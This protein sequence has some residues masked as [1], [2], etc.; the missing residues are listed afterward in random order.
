MATPT[1]AP[2]SAHADDAARTIG[3]Y[4]KCMRSRIKRS[5]RGEQNAE[6]LLVSRTDGV[7]SIE[8]YGG[9]AERNASMAA[10]V[11]ELDASG[12]LGDFAPA[13]VQTGDRCVARRG[14]DGAVELH[15]WQ[16]QPVPDELRARLPLRRVLSMCATPRYADVPVPD[17]CFDAWPAAGVAAGG[18]DDACAALAAAGAA[19][20]ADLRLGWHGTAHHHPSRLRLL[21]LAAAHPDRLACYD[22]VGAE[23]A[24]GGAAEAAHRTLLEQVASYAYLLDVQGKGYSSRLKL[25]LHAGRPL[26]IARRPWEEY[27]MAGLVPW[28]HYVPVAENLGDLVERVAWADSH[29]A[30]AAAIAAAAQQFAREHLTRAAAMRALAHALVSGTRPPV[31]GGGGEAV[32]A[33][34][35]AEAEAANGAIPSGGGGDDDDS[36][37]TRASQDR[38]GQQSYYYWHANRTGAVAGMPQGAGA[39]PPPTPQRLATTAAAAATIAPDVRPIATFQLVDDGDVVKVRIALEGD[40]DGAFAAEGTPWCGT[41][42]GDVDFECGE[43][44]LKLTVRARGAA[45]A[46]REFR[47]WVDE[48]AHAI[49]PEQC[50]WRV[51]K[52]R[53]LVVS[54][55]KA[56]RYRSWGKLRMR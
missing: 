52:A 5:G 20:P 18:F 28:T 50:A 44:S 55:R 47:L 13:L 22:V 4:L 12:A 11:R 39:A 23:A 6:M 36:S 34:A 37:K 29:P 30:E 7:L 9:W 41:S 16:R 33:A 17:W 46:A 24:G 43:R 48:L 25:L 2:E 53:R 51:T 8:D 40:L 42:A 3:G 21:E 45:D 35:E 32:A 56:D 1:P 19:P 15:L 14:A 27:Y 38:H 26:F 49:V 54:L 31:G 10:M